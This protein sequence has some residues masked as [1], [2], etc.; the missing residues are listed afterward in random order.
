MK[1]RRRL[2]YAIGGFVLCVAVGVGILM[3]THTE[4]S[5]S[6]FASKDADT[7]MNAFIDAFWMPRVDQFAEDLY[8]DKP[9]LFW[10][11][12]LML[13]VLQDAYDRSGNKSYYD[14]VVKLS[15]SI[16]QR[17]GD[18]WLD[19]PGSNTDHL[20]D[21]P[22]WMTLAFLRS[23]EITN[24]ETYLQAARNTF[25]GIWN[26]YADE[27]LGGGIWWNGVARTDKNTCN[28]G[29]AAIAA[30]KLSQALQDDSYLNKAKSLYEWEKRNL[31]VNGRVLDHVTKNRDGSTDIATWEFTYNQGVFIGAAHF[32]FQATKDTAYL[33]DAIAAADYS[34]Q[35]LTDTNY[36]L[37]FDS[38]DGVE[39]GA[40]FKG[41]FVRYMNLLI[42]KDG[43]KQYAAWMNLNAATAWGNRRGSDNLMYKD[44]SV[45]TPDGAITS[46]GM[47][48]GVALLQ[49][50]SPVKENMKL[51]KAPKAA[52][53]VRLA[54]L[55]AYNEDA[56]S[57]KA[58]PGDF[59]WSGENYAY[60]AEQVP[61]RITFEGTP[62][63]LGPSGDGQ[64]NAIRAEGQT[65]ELPPGPYREI[66]ILAAGTNGRQLAKELKLN[67]REQGS[68][69]NQANI[70]MADWTTDDTTG[71]KVAKSYSVVRSASGD[72]KKAS[73]MYAYY[74]R[75][76]PGLTL[77]SVTLPN[78]FANNVNI[79]AITLISGE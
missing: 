21:D 25:D 53:T 14:Y 35:H 22:M 72:L 39:A 57:T 51:P 17:Y 18:N 79:F 8:K 9:Q 55:G 26:K 23:Y 69:P 3:V 74:V 11:Q 66:R 67:Y 37:Q 13:E 15:D 77:T 71:Q 7:A 65:I 73:R 30:V 44:W 24:N 75:T 46:W 52:T 59:A 1:M 29:A 49:T 41:I 63:L 50:T 43:Q 36:I 10:K 48:T 54:D 16:L 40:G 32:L 20:T 68:I 60:P 31:Y 64:K 47:E 2:G 62:Y 58:K 78:D 33:N 38:E 42:N 70:V 76:T 5:A 27:E 12:A 28:N 61:A 56:F 45:K 6:G 19:G 34:V 4:R